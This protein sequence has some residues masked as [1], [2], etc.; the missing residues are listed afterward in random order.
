MYVSTLSVGNLVNALS[1]FLCRIVLFSLK[2]CINITAMITS[3]LVVTAAFNVFVAITLFTHNTI[4]TPQ[5]CYVLVV[6]S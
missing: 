3:S 6:E 2:L 1:P 4:L 5:Q